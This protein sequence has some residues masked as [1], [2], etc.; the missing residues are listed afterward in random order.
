[1]KKIIIRESDLDLYCEVKLLNEYNKF[2]NKNNLTNSNESY[3][4]F[5]I[6]FLAGRKNKKGS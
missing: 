1:M 5:L 3:S 2:L 4:K 6:E